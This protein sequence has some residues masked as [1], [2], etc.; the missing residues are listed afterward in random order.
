MEGIATIVSRYNKRELGIEGPGAYRTSTD[1]DFFRGDVGTVDRPD[2]LDDADP[3]VITPSRWKAFTD[4]GLTESMTRE[5]WGASKWVRGQLRLWAVN[6]FDASQ[7][8]PLGKSVSHEIFMTIIEPLWGKDMDDE[9]K[10]AVL[11]R[12]C[13]IVAT[14]QWLYY[15]IATRDAIEVPRLNLEDKCGMNEDNWSLIAPS[16]RPVVGNWLESVAEPPTDY[17]DQLQWEEAWMSAVMSNGD[18]DIPL[19]GPPPAPANDGINILPPSQTQEIDAANRI[20][21]DSD[22]Q[23]RFACPQAGKG[24]N[25]FSKFRI[26]RKDRSILG[27]ASSSSA[28]R[29]SQELFP[30]ETSSSHTAASSSAAPSTTSAPPI[31]LLQKGSTWGQPRSHFDF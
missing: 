22:G 2:G 3:K 27:N 14:H 18:V 4:V 5:R 1:L 23:Y 16:A 26:P 12:S 17:Q 31:G 19:L 25:L 11:K 24:A 9:S 10:L 13:L 7:E 30:T 8:P 15:R 28:G 6:P 29:S 21:A 20:E